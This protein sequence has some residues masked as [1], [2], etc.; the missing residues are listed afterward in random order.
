VAELCCYNASEKPPGPSRTQS[1]YFYIFGVAPHQVTEGT[2][3]GY[4]NPTVNQPSLVKT[5]YIW[6]QST[7]DTENTS[8]YYC[9][10]AKIVKYIS[11]I[12]PRTSITVLP[13]RLVVKP[14]DCC[15][16]ASLMVAS[17]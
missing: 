15:D 13:Y 17:Q 9:P 16:L 3:V 5:L 4:F 12:A 6:A 11:A 1:P 2:F 8:I 10:D 7:M 14:V